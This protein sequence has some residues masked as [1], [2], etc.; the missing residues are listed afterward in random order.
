MPR[1][2][3]SSCHAT[4]PLIIGW[5][6]RYQF[7]PFKKIV[8]TIGLPNL[9]DFV[10]IL[11]LMRP[12]SENLSALASDLN[13]FRQEKA[14]KPLKITKKSPMFDTEFDA[15]HQKDIKVISKVAQHCS[16]IDLTMDLVSEL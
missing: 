2:R 5:E 10:R 6:V 9:K 1:V 7:W 13:F 12:E 11:P 3:G 14:P 15:L 8:R 4:G 16:N